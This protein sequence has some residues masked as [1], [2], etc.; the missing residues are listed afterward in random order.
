[1]S[2]TLNQILRLFLFGFDLNLR[3]L[4]TS[5]VV[6]IDSDPND[7]DLG[8]V[9]VDLK[10]VLVRNLNKRN[11]DI[12]IISNLLLLNVDY[13]KSGEWEDQ[14]FFFDWMEGKFI[15]L[16]SFGLFARHTIDVCLR[17]ICIS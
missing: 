11:Q 6:G 13:L 16:L 17:T 1:M 15:F 5:K 4:E 7:A 9:L 12:I 2:L 3:M 14:N 8:N 10:E